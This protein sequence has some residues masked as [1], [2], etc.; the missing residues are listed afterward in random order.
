MKSTI[1]RP[2]LFAAITLGAAFGL[3][4][5]S[6]YHDGYGYGYG[7]VGM[8]YGGYSRPY[9]GW[10]D[11]YYYPGSGYYIY[12]RYGSRHRWND[13]HRSYWES[14]RPSG[15][16][17]DNWSGYQQQHRND[18]HAAASGGH[19]ARNDGHAAASGGHRSGNDGHRARSSHG[20]SGGHGSQ[21]HGGGGHSGG[22]GGHSRRH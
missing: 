12:D 17:R 10:Y 13:Q 19:R 9:Y 6:T 2:A 1:L 8:G 7:R 15:H 5:C 11:N 22:G 18:G 20:N 21:S 3:A 4:G 16:H 14:R